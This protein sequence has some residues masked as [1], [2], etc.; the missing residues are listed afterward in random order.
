MK[1]ILSI[2]ILWM[3]CLPLL[4]Q[5]GGE[6]TPTYTL[7][8]ACVPQF[9][10]S[11]SPSEAMSYTEGQNVYV[12][13]SARTG[14]KFLFW[15]KGD[16]VVS[17]N[18]YFYYKMPAEDV[19]LTAHFEYNPD[20]PGNPETPV[21]PTTYELKATA[22]PALAGST[23]Y[24]NPKR[25]EAGQ[26]VYLYASPRTG[27]KFLKWLKGSEVVSTDYYFYY[28]MPAE[29]VEL[30]AMFEY[31]PD[32]LDNPNK[33]HYDAAT[34][35]I[36]IDDFTPGS[37]YS[38][39][40]N[41]ASGL[42]DGDVVQLIVSGRMETN[43]L[44]YV[45]YRMPTVADLSRTYGYTEVGSNGLG[46]NTKLTTLILPGCVEKISEYAFSSTP[47]INSLTLYS[48]TPPVTGNRMLQN[49]KPENGVVLYVPAAS[50]GLYTEH[51]V[52]GKYTILPI[53]TNVLS[54]SVSLPNDLNLADYA[55][56]YLRLQNV[57]GQ[58]IEYVVNATQRTY[59]FNNI[60][61][62]SEW[63]AYMIKGTR[64]ISDY[65]H[66][67]VADDDAQTTIS[68]IKPLQSVTLK[69]MGGSKD[70]TS[71][72]QVGI[73]FLGSDGSYLGR[74]TT[75]GGVLSGTYVVPQVSLSG[76]LSQ[77]YK[78]P[79]VEGITVKD[80]A[81]DNIVTVNLTPRATKKMTVTVTDGTTPV[82]GAVVCLAQ[83]L[84]NGQVKTFTVVTNEKGE[85]E[86]A[87]LEGYPVTVTITAEGFGKFETT[88]EAGTESLTP[89]LT[90]LEGDKITL[91]ASIF[92]PNFDGS[93]T[94][95]VIDGSNLTYMFSLF[96]YAF[97]DKTT[98]EPLDI[99]YSCTGNVIQVNGTLPENA[100]I[101][102]S[103]E[104]FSCDPIEYKITD[105][106]ETTRQH[107][108]E[109]T[110]LVHGF[111]SV[112]LTTNATDFVYAMLF[113]SDGK[114]VKRMTYDRDNGNTVL[115]S[116]LKG[117]Y[118][119][120]SIPRMVLDGSVASLS[121]LDEMGF[122]EGVHYSKNELKGVKVL[123][124]LIVNAVYNLPDNY[125]ELFAADGKNFLYEA[126]G[127]GRSNKIT[128]NKS[129][130]TV[131]S[132]VTIGVK[133]RFS[134]NRHPNDLNVIVDLGEGNEYVEGSLICNGRALNCTVDSDNRLHINATENDG[135][136]GIRFC[137][138][139][140]K[141]GTYT[142]SCYL[143]FRMLGTNYKVLVG[144][145]DFTA[146]EMDFSVPTVT[147]V[148]GIGVS[149]RT[150]PNATVEVYNYNTLI[151]RTT[152]LADGSW[153][154]KLPSGS[155]EEYSEWKEQ[156]EG[157][158]SLMPSYAEWKH[159]YCL[160]LTE[161]TNNLHVEVM[162][163]G[164]DSS[165]ASGMS[166]FA[167][168]KV[169]ID[170]SGLRLVSETKAVTYDPTINMAKTAS[171]E[172]YNGWLHKNVGIDFDL[173]SQ[174][175]SSNS[176]MFYTTTMFTFT[177]EFIRDEP[178]KI[179]QVTIL[180]AT[181]SGQELELAASY[182]SSTKKYFATKE[183][184]WGDLPV[185]MGATWV[186]KAEE[187]PATT[188]RVDGDYAPGTMGFAMRPPTDMA[189]YDGSKPVPIHD[190]SG[191]VYEAVGSNRLEGVTATVFYKEQYEDMYGDPHER[192]VMWNAEE[193]AQQNPQFTDAQGI[194]QWDVPK[195]LWQV[196][197]EKTGYETTYSDW[198]PV[199]PPQLDVNVGM[200]QLVQPAV[201][202]ARVYD[203]RVDVEFTLYMDALTLTTD[204]IHV[205]VDGIEVEGT[206]TLDNA[207]TT[208]NGEA[209]YA[210]KLHF[211]PADA[212]KLKDG[213]VT[214]IVSKDVKAYNGY[215]LAQTYEQPMNVVLRA[216][217]IDVAEEVEV[218]T[219]LK[220]QATITVTPAEAAAG[221]KLLVSVAGES[222][223]KIVSPA[224]SDVPV[225]FDATGKAT[226]TIEGGLP[227]ETI[228]SW[229]L[230]DTDLSAET[231]LTVN[232]PRKGDVKIDNKVDMLDVKEVL[233]LAA[234]NGFGMAAD[235]N[236]D[237]RIDIADIQAILNV[238]ANKK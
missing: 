116:G 117:D 223:G 15:K 103:P 206:I 172:F 108:A 157:K 146:T 205:M 166:D 198:L 140:S 114:F 208:A 46:S 149:G 179:S 181:E 71:D 158:F 161:G 112:T 160:M 24:D 231:K 69:V 95:Y 11:L 138:I 207:E 238:I 127:Q 151:G 109:A 3:A 164:T 152:S 194:Y 26:E 80:N 211:T 58:T 235:V 92:Y 21:I 65:T 153:T 102:A 91:T 32:N 184:A 56:S 86:A 8:T 202:L 14:F 23:N 53:T 57:N 222:I 61:K 201:R 105:Y 9:A 67:S 126:P 10:A 121:E 220:K 59:I 94:E 159:L 85:A 225:T 137:T 212:A 209:T 34:K 167:T 1:K 221:K 6:V 5:G 118:T 113:D 110:I 178:D 107:E 147:P 79:E 77:V 203:D 217:T 30:T 229:Q 27:F 93:L 41:V 236:N 115:F 190:P 210:T 136:E 171:F 230:D 64:V 51:E 232:K 25:F 122:T 123:D 163:G 42:K 44:Y 196:K 176:Y 37:F 174:T 191:Y 228:I 101:I 188:R 182:D 199:P 60:Q 131:G 66:V 68:G 63:D 141:A 215:G 214:V 120:V 170:G 49:L 169:G 195:G 81:A 173:I 187:T 226:V 40:S 186:R 52:W 204:Q 132:Y 78:V 233:T 227:G 219:T 134:N 33:N 22:Q 183:L 180:V 20:G 75:L 88:V 150:W 168:S 155:E 197:F 17:T 35:T 119:I 145:T 70:Y 192:V 185:A 144:S 129:E 84:E 7:T 83:Q 193:Y 28:T 54:V 162:R 165:R 100:S 224:A 4:A 38:A 139:P 13:A 55:D 135:L 128:V 124:Y 106:D 154:L 16:E 48:Y 125:E 31:N 18:Y 43:D 72:E 216:K 47:N 96:N 87:C 177:T 98:K 175:C 97:V 19:T 104:G 82:A 73:T 2:L 12:N 50:V 62:K 133:Y 218:T 148:P 36:I 90:K 130:V 76:T 156:N 39:Y 29:D 213:E 99:D 111:A 89:V 200:K 142:P 189:F 237:G 74:G 143:T 234:K 45:Y